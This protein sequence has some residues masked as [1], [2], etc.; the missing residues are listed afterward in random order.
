[1]MISMKALSNLF[2]ETINYIHH[3]NMFLLWEPHFSMFCWKNWASHVRWLSV[4]Q[5]FDQHLVKRLYKFQWWYQWRLCQI[6]FVKQWFEHTIQGVYTQKYTHMPLT[7]TGL[8][9]KVSKLVCLMCF[10]LNYNISTGCQICVCIVKGKPT[11]MCVWQW[12]ETEFGV[13]TLSN[14]LTC[15]S[16]AGLWEVW[17]VKTSVFDVFYIEVSHLNW[18]PNLLWVYA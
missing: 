14:T 9:D 13:F 11:W 2:Y 5:C 18:M 12:Y 17:G 15:L 6:Y 1:M 7:V 16:Q 4:D 10:T 3:I 8:L